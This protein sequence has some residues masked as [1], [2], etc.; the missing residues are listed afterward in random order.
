MAAITTFPTITG[1]VELADDVYTFTTTVA[2]KRGQGVAFNA[3]GVDFSV[4]VALL[5]SDLRLA[6]FA[7]EDADANTTVRVKLLGPILYL[8]NGT[9]GVIDAGTE[10]M[11]GAVGS[12]DAATAGNLVVGMTLA[13][14]AA[15]SYGA[16]MIYKS[17]LE[18]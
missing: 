8:G 5:A 14:M 11:M 10:V 15:S 7:L 13:D 2:L 3:T 16:V 4:E 18:T 9:D 17:A 1:S 12:V 6:G